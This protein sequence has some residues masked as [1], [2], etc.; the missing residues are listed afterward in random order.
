MGG[1]RVT[2]S[3]ISGGRMEYSKVNLK[4]KLGKFS[5]H[6]APRIV[7]QFNDYHIKLVKVEGEF[8]WHTH[9]E[10]DELFLVLTGSL[11]I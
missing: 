2:L 8:S 11:D 3:T 7:S 10:T 1:D 5:D 4:E 6:W 9:I